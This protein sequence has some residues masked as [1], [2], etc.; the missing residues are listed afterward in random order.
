MTPEAVVP[1]DSGSM[2]MPL[3]PVPIPEGVIPRQLRRAMSRRAQLVDDPR[4][5]RLINDEGDG[6]PGLIID[7]FDAHFA[8]QTTSRAMDARLDEIARSLVEVAGARSVILRNDTSRREVVGLERDRSHV[9][10]GSPPRWTR[11]LELGARITFDLHQGFETGYSYALREVRRALERLSQNQ[12]VLDPACLVGGTIIQAGLHGARHAVAFA[13]D[14]EA[15]DLARENVEANGLMSR[16]RVAAASPMEALRAIHDT[17]DL[18]LLHAPARGGDG[19]RWR[20]EFGELLQLSLRATRH[21]GRLVVAAADA[22]LGA[23]PLEGYVLRACEQEGRA[24]WR[25]LR[26]AAPPDFP[27]VAGAPEALASVVL[28]IN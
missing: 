20:K 18:V 9:L 4:H 25:L 19:R 13:E 26:P 2:E 7:R 6:L 1:P 17:F 27:A 28:E 5:C 3:E 16:A 21:G 24:A 8:V 14:P 11:L 10:T 23:T 22:A 15:A 12:R